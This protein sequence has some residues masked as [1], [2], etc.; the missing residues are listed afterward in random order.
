MDFKKLKSGSDVR[1]VAMGENA[2]LTPAVAQTLGRA[3]V[4]FLSQK[5]LKKPEQLTIAVG[6][7]S[8]L[9]GPRL[10]EAVLEGIISTGATAADYEM[11]TTPSMYMAILTEGFQPDASIMITASHHPWQLNGLKFFT[12]EG[13]LGFHELDEACRI[14]KTPRKSAA[15]ALPAYLPETFGRTDYLRR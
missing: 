8:R 4:A 13:G 2:V 10:L 6:R 3:F 12:K 14:G 1:G 7:D 5:L 11:C 15:Y 9:S